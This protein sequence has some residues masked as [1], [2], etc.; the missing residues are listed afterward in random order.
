[1]PMIRLFII[2]Q[3]FYY[4]HPGNRQFMHESQNKPKIKSEGSERKKRLILGGRTYTVDDDDISVISPTN[5]KN[6]NTDRVDKS[7]TIDDGIVKGAEV[8]KRYFFIILLIS[9]VKLK[10]FNCLYL[11][12]KSRFEAFQI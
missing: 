2:F 10:C 6:K 8:D 1:M 5:D 9:S 4:S 12:S 11:I 7:K 3:P